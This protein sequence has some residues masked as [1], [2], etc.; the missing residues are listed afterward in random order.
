MHRGRDLIGLTVLAGP[1]L[2]RIGRVQ[3][4]LLS[5]DGTRICGLVLEGAGW[6]HPARVL[7]FR[8]VQAIGETH[9][10][11]QERY[12]AQGEGE[13][14]R[15]CGRLRGLPV[16]TADGREMGLLDDLQFEPGSGRVLALELSRGLVDDLLRGKELVA[17][18]GP[19][20]A[21]EAAVIM[22][23]AGGD[24]DLGGVEGEMS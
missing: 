5:E 13:A 11:A 19:V 21:G 17:L 12:L 24:Y 18:P 15:P 16:L 2:T 7:D 3:E 6:L 10:V 1:R 22:G 4:L 9:L 8:A 23:E 14:P 20:V